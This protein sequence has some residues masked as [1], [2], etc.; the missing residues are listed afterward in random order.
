MRK[1]SLVGAPLRIILPILLLF[2]IGCVN[3]EVETKFKSDGSGV[4]IWH[5][6]SSALMAGQIKEYVDSHP[7]LKHGKRILDEYKEGEYWLAQE[8]PF[9]KVS[10]L[11]DEGHEVRFQTKGWLRRTSTY[12]EFWKKKLGGRAG[13][14]AEK[15]GNI[16][17]IKVKWQVTMPGK[18]QESNADE[19]KEGVAVWNLTLTDFAA[20]H[21][22]SARSTHWNIPA[23]AGMAIAALTLFGISFFLF[24]K[25]AGRKRTQCVGCGT[26]ISADADYCSKCGKLQKETQ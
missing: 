14:I 24:Q 15:A 25:N 22:F 2:A 8:I 16:L 20:Q 6:T 1:K 12:S 7:L 26:L 4:Q 18:I 23:L 10:E 13:P 11:Q 21:S 3:L 19:I 9:Q 5:F 17:P